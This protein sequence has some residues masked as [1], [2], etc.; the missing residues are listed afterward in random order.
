MAD[1]VDLVLSVLK[2]HFKPRIALCTSKQANAQNLMLKVDIRLRNAH[3]FL[4]VVCIC[5]TCMASHI[6]WSAWILLMLFYDDVSGKYRVGCFSMRAKSL[7]SKKQISTGLR[8][9][10]KCICSGEQ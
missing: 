5:Y 4:K 7:I 1:F 9:M 6:A 3:V 10:I 8:K 2:N